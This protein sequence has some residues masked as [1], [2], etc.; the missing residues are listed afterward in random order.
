MNYKNILVGALGV[1]IITNSLTSVLVFAQVA[2]TERKNPIERNIP[3]GRDFCERIDEI[4]S[5]VDQQVTNRITSLEV[6]R[7]RGINKLTE[8]RN[9]RNERALEN[10]VKRDRNRTEHYA[11][12]ETRATTD[13]QRAAVAAFRA[14]TEL[15]IT[16]R[17]TALDSATQSFRQSLNQEITARQTAVD[18]AVNTFQSS[19]ITAINQAKS[20]CAAGVDAKTVRETFHTNIR[21]A[22]AQFNNERQEIEKRKDLIEPIRVIQRQAIEKAIADFKTTMEKART[23]L[24]AAFQQ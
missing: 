15:A 24:Q 19:R 5:R 14:T 23:D 12:L 13:A 22:Q 18:A 9:T 8:R 2:P 21:V 7:Q 1:I 11:K 20:G 17:K 3:A 6:Q 16:A 4:I 10:Q